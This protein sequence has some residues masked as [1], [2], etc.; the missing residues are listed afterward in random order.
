MSTEEARSNYL[1]SLITGADKDTQENIRV[2]LLRLKSTMTRKENIQAIA[3]ATKINIKDLSETLAYLHG[4]LWR[5]LLKA[6]RRR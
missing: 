6:F 3:N 5:P 2:V 4:Q 1:G